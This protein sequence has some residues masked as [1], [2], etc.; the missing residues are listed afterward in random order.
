MTHKNNVGRKRD[1]FKTLNCSI[2]A[3]QKLRF[4]F[5]RKARWV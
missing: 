1:D 3:V 5:P 2:S 4:G